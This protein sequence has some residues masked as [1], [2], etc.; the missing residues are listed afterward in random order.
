MKF[1]KVYKSYLIQ[2]VG[3][4]NNIMLEKVYYQEIHFFFLFLFS[5]RLLQET[6]PC[7]W[8]LPTQERFV[9]MRKSS[10]RVCSW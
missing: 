1:I 7:A 3:L 4:R 6:N 2:A 5:V 8:R 9:F 10:K